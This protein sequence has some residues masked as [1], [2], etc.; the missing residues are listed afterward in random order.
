MNTINASTGFSPF[1]LRMGRSPRLIPPLITSPT[2]VPLDDA[3]ETAA[4]IELIESLALNVKEA[5]DNLLAAKVN[6]AEYANRSRGKEL[7]VQPGNKVLLSTEHR[8]REYMQTGSGRSA[9]FMPRFD[10]PYQTTDAH[11][12]KSNYTLNLPNEPLRHP[13]FHSS[14]LRKFVDN[15]DSLFPSRALP[16]PGPVVTADGEQEWLIDR[17]IDERWRGRGHQYLVRWQGWGPEEDRWIAGSELGET[18]ALEIWLKAE[19]GDK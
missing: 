8:R 1:Q 16:K 17:I 10:G 19:E 11:P 4:A 13:S 12:E 6:Q 7:S 14:L 9:K 18:E 5:Q 2:P 15:D 3:R